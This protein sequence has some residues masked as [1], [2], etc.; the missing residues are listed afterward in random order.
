[1]DG[2]VGQVV[3]ANLYLLVSN[4][5]GGSND[6]Q[7]RL[8]RWSAGMNEPETVLEGLRS[9]G[10]KARMPPRRWSPACWPTGN[11]STASTRAA[12]R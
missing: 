10:M 8:E 5:Y 11:A 3:G 4:L 7:V 12:V 2:P 1:M 9:Y 6:G